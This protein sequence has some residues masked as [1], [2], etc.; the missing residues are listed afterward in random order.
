LK[1][2]QVIYSFSTGAVTP[3]NTG[4]AGVYNGKFAFACEDRF[5][6]CYDIE[7][8]AFLWKS[9][10]FSYPWGDFWSYDSSSWN[11]ML[12]AGSYVGMVA[13][14]W[15]T[16]KILWQTPAYSAPFETPYEGQQAW[17]SAT[18]VA[19][20]KLYS[21][22]DEH[23]ATQPLTRGWKWYCFNATT[24]A[25][26]WSIDGWNSDAR[27]FSGSCS[28]GYLAAANQYDGTMYV[29]GAGQSSMTVAAPNVVVPKGS[30]VVITGTVLDQSPGQPNTPCV[31]HDSMATQMQ[32]LH[33]GQPIAGIWGNETI[34][35]VPVTLT[36]LD[37][38]GNV[39]NIGTTTTNGY[40][41]TF[42]YTWAPPNEGQYTILAA[43]AGDDSYGSSGAAT[44][45]SVGP[46]PTVAPTAT[47]A[48]PQ[49]D[50]MPT[51]TGIL[52][53]V[54]VAIVVSVIALVVVLRK[55]A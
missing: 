32:Y 10:L 42:G 44:T 38:N 45:I 48:A 2:G 55:H 46:A 6:Q 34:T 20:G 7:T 50:Y 11:N 17:H 3:F 30:G 23:T 19:D 13:M 43:F 14:D 1:T 49:T 21:Y 35:G 25:V 22:T 5:W 24:G 33:M 9:P 53:A 15:D 37:S 36:A 26:M 16:G 47:P 52:V 31:S 4:C 39:L 18:I 8:G 40:Y 54:I 28:D 29:F 27:T 12:Y 41:G 51:L